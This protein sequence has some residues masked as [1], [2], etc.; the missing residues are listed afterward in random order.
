MAFGG[1]N[2]NPGPSFPP[3]NQTQFGNF[4]TSST[5]PFP[6]IS[7][8]NNN[9]PSSQRS[10]R[11]DTGMGYMFDNAGSG[12]PSQR[13]GSLPLTMER[14]PSNLSYPFEESQRSTISPPKWGAYP[15][16]SFGDLNPSK[17][18]EPSSVAPNVNSP[19]VATSIPARPSNFQDPRRNRA[20]P[21]ADRDFLDNYAQDVSERWPTE[22]SNFQAPQ[23]TRSPPLQSGNEF[24]WRKSHPIESDT[25]REI[26]SPSNF[27][28]TSAISVNNSNS[29][30]QQRS[31]L[32][33][34]QNEAEG[35]RSKRMNSQVPKRN[36]SPSLASSE[37]H[38][39]GTS[40]SPQDDTEREMQAKAKRLARFG[41]ELSQP[42]QRSSDN[43]KHK[44]PANRHDQA[45]VERHNLVS[46]QATE[47]A[48]DSMLFEYEGSESSNVI[49]GLCPDMCP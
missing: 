2:K 17:H 36:R 1:F 40:Y 28:N 18:Q 11:L 47:A 43:V 12:A 15:K 7:P 35:A 16:S 14:N 8:F 3:R 48:G 26:I 5:S 29:P 33:T 32:T 30:I 46:D 31:F 39:P 24:T 13:G 44:S 22:P 42:V 19:N 20:S 10:P 49:I 23:R 4:P 9:S 37:E 41:V 45:L 21:Y 6:P 25:D 38:L 27:G 34:P